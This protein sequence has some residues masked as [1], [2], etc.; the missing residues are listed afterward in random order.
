MEWGKKENKKI[1]QPAPL[2]SSVIEWDDD[3]EA[4]MHKIT[5]DKIK[6]LLRTL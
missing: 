3:L 1:G 5:S 2:K 4:V 6:D